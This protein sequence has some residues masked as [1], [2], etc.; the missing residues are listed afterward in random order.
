MKAKHL[1]PLLAAA[2]LGGSGCAS[3]PKS[4]SV[5]KVP[6]GIQ[7]KADA[8]TAD[9]EAALPELVE[10][11]EVEENAFVL[12]GPLSPDD[13][14]LL[15]NGKRIHIM[16]TIWHWHSIFGVVGMAREF[17]EERPRRVFKCLKEA[18]AKVPEADALIDVEIRDV[19]SPPMSLIPIYAPYQGMHL[20]GVPVK[21]NEGVFE[22]LKEGAG[23]RSEDDEDDSF[24]DSEK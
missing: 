9:P 16:T 19:S 5:L 21:L 12:G 2:V 8:E 18:F 11:F 13:Y 24:P 15:N 10:P 1:L 17:K 22:K 3:F 20:F 4:P 23:V 7:W 6:K 14:T